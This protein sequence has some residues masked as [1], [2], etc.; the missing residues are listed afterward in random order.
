M[1]PHITHHTSLLPSLTSHH[2]SLLASLT[3]HHTSLLPSLISHHTSLLPSLISHPSPIPHHTT[4]HCTCLLASHITHHTPHMSPRIT[5]HTSHIPHVSLHHTP[6]MSPRITH[7]SSRRSAL[8]SVHHPSLHSSF[9]PLLLS[10]GPAHLPEAGGRMQSRVRG[11]APGHCGGRALRGGLP[12]GNAM[13]GMYSG[14]YCLRV[15]LWGCSL[16][17]GGAD[18]LQGVNP[19]CSPGINSLLGLG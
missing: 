17:G 8:T 19:P 2:T 15:K 1:S 6:H 12:Q 11:T 7:V 18:S 3:S 16:C 4:L 13:E 9:T 5:H 14:G 10:A